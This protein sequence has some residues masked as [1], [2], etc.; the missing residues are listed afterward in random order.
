MRKTLA[1]L[2]ATAFLYPAASPPLSIKSQTLVAPAKFRTVAN[3]IPNRY[4]VVLATTDF[5]PIA[6]PAPTPIAATPAIAQASAASAIS[7]DSSSTPSVA[8]PIPAD[9]QVVATADG[10]DVRLRRHFQSHL[11]RSAQGLSPERYRGGGDSDERGLAG[12]IR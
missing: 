2:L 7:P 4:I 8:E 9:P 3:P 5:S 11:E 12:R 1:L 6:G 10:P